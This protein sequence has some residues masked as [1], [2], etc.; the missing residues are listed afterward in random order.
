MAAISSGIA[1]AGCLEGPFSTRGN[2]SPEPDTAEQIQERA[3]S[4]AAE[5]RTGDPTEMGSGVSPDVELFNHTS[6]AL[7]VT[8]HAVADGEEFLSESF[9]VPSGETSQPEKSYDEFKGAGTLTVRIS[10]EDGPSGSHEFEDTKTD[11]KTYVSN[12]TPTKSKS[13]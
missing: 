2:D 13:P 3:T 6:A 10:V 12:F 5:A 11:L 9:P 4:P 1:T 8:L 7:M